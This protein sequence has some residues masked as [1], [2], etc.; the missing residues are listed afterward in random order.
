[1]V[2]LNLK[3]FKILDMNFFLGEILNFNDEYFFLIV[4]YLDYLLL[5]SRFFEHILILV[6]NI[7]IVRNKST[8]HK[9]GV[10]CVTKFSQFSKEQ[11]LGPGWTGCL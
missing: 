1:M 7:V 2:S 6:M 4:I 5:N 11:A 3:N 10:N 9:R 8:K